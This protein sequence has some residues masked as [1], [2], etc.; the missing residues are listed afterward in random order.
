[1]I[2]LRSEEK[3]LKGAFGAEF[4]SYAQRVPA[5]IPFLF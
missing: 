2:R 5:V 3:L 4:D 1:V